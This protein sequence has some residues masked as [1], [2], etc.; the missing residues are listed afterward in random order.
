MRSKIISSMMTELS[1]SLKVAVQVQRKAEEMD[2][3]M[4]AVERISLQY[5][6]GTQSS[7]CSFIYFTLDSLSQVCASA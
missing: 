5:C 6:V 4:A 3:V 7:F 2:V 1:H